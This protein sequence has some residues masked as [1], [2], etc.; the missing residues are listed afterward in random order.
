MSTEQN[1]A[2]EKRVFEELNKGNLAIIDELF[3]PSY[4]YHG[5]AG[6][7]AKGPE[8]FKQIM[9]MARAGFPD[10]NM[11]IEDMIA[12]GDMVATRATYSGTHK[13]EFMGIPPTDKHFSMAAQV[14]VRFA[15][16]EE[17]EAWGIG[18]MVTMLQQLGVA[19]PM[20]QPGT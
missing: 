6:M 16:G 7:E 2:V 20:G 11:E 10:W 17:V 4:V 15:D 18:D 1:K 9:T 12:E 5:P 14:M 8:G 3:A 13:G 19:P